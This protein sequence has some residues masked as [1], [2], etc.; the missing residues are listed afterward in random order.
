MER[1]TQDYFGITRPVALGTHRW[2]M[3]DPTHIKVETD[4]L[5]WDEQGVET[6]FY[7]PTG[8]EP[9]L[10]QFCTLADGPPEEILGFTRSFGVLGICEHGWHYRHE[11]GAGR[12]PSR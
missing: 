6:R 9:I 12:V 5:L 10:Q 4:R 2:W 3:P 11:W 1:S 8:S 7:E